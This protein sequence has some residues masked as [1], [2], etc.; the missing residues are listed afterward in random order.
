[1][2]AF[3]EK[4]ANAVPYQFKDFTGYRL[5]RW[6]IFKPT[7]EPW[8]KVSVDAILPKV[9]VGDGEM[10][11]SAWI[12]NYQPFEAKISLARP[13]LTLSN[14]LAEAE[15]VYEAKP[16]YAAI[17]DRF[18]RVVN[19]CTYELNEMEYLSRWPGEALKRLRKATERAEKMLASLHC[20]PGRWV[21]ARKAAA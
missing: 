3:P 9:K 5:G 20:D 13:M 15:K 14:L 17:T 18:L 7:G 4:A 6:Y 11:A 8:P 10:T 2:F 1:M 16:R 21:T 12:D 19:S